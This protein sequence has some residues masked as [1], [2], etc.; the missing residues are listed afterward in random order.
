MIFGAFAVTATPAFAS[1]SYRFGSRTLY[2]GMSGH[3]VMWLQRNLTKIGYTT[4][5]TAEFNGA[6]E[7]QVER[8]QRQNKINAN[9]VVGPATFERILVALH[10]ITT[11]SK[12]TTALAAAATGGTGLGAATWPTGAGADAGAPVEKATLSDGLAVAPADAPTVIKEVIAAAD[13][14]AFK[15]YVYGGGHASFT[16]AGYDCSGSV[17]YALHGGGLLSSPLDSTDFA[18]YGSSGAGRWITIWTEPG[19][20]TYMQV[21]GL[22]FDTAAQSS[23]NGDDR[24]STTRISPAAGFE[25]LHPTGW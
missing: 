24:W 18:A 19:Y 10:T 6:T 16:S 5:V 8:F 20:H 4:R 7:V 23:S 22:W 12:Q 11:S 13:K 17:S 2:P 3:D 9:G 14:I 1:T 21:A 25:E 15:P